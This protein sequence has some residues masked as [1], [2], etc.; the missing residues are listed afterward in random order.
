[1]WP[2]YIPSRFRSQ[3]ASTLQHLDEA[4]ISYHVIIHPSEKKEYQQNYPHA[5]II[6]TDKQVS[7]SSARQFILDLAVQQK[8]KWIWMLDDDLTKFYHRHKKELKSM[9][10]KSWM[11]QI[12][13]IIKEQKLEDHQICH[14]GC[15]H[16]TFSM[17]SKPFSLNT[18]LGAIGLFHIPTLA[19]LEIK[20]DMSLPVME[21]TDLIIQILE[22]GYFNIKLS[23]FVFYSQPAGLKN[24]SGGLSKT[25]QQKG[26]QKGIL[27]FQ[28]K[29]PHLIILDKKHDTKY[30]IKWHYFRKKKY[31]ELMEYLTPKIM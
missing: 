8:K 15:Q 28:K 3:N 10:L 21:D 23:S 25:Y 16:T 2:I 5:K 24:K 31:Q 17:M 19:K 29:H 6:E 7:V 22:K 4:K 14:V 11:S 20:Y 26:K 1:M 27:L 18:N 9:N 13:D 12:E 30:R